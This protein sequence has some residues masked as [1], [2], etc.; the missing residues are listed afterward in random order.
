MSN[1]LIASNEPLFCRGVSVTLAA[2]EIDVVGEAYSL[3]ETVLKA[4]E[5][6]PDVI[7]V[8]ARLLKEDRE[9]A[10]DLLQLHAKTKL[11]CLVDQERADL[12][13][14]AA[15]AEAVACLLRSISANELSQAMRQIIQEGATI[16]A[17]LVPLVL[18][19]LRSRLEPSG[20]ATLTEREREI[21]LLLVE[22]KPNRQ[23]AE[24]CFISE[25]TVRSHLSNM[26][27]KLKCSSKT[28]VIRFAL[29]NGLSE[30]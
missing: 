8:D 17:K 20:I 6:D 23:I 22:G 27:N 2:D 10:A 5:L 12:L 26:I 25:N 16:S 24:E 29:N 15:K 14:E 30:I 21:L 19:R 3:Q 7:I 13:D 1:V 11:V 18:K 4:K 28:D 9:V